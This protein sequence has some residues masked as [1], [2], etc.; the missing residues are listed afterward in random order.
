[1]LAKV[2][3]G[4]KAQ[5]LIARFDQTLTAMSSM[6]NTLLDINQIDSRAVR[7]A[8]VTFPVRE[9]LDVLRDEFACLA[10][11]H[12]I[13]LHVVCSLWVYSDR[14]LLE[15]MIRNLLSNALKYAIGGKVL[16][17]CRR[18]N[19]MLSIEVCDTGA[20]IPAEELRAI[21][22]E[23]RQL[24]NAARERSQGL[25]LGLSIV[26]GLGTLLEHRV[27]VVLSQAADRSSASNL[28][29]LKAGVKTEWKSS[30]CRS[31][32]S[33]CCSSPRRDFNHR[34]RS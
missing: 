33:C 21:F 32:E 11:D 26:K 6:L 4:E 24:D 22:E 30:T 16:L 8:K 27:Y 23:Y 29:C 19:G 34:G 25:G 31:T 1:M 14:R 28:P 15:Q 12:R 9:L 13:S 7:V 3:E 2:V 10:E 17:G 20:G 5:T 18:R